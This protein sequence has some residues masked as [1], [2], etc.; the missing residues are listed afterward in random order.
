MG[1]KVGK[2]YNLIF[3]E[4]VENLLKSIPKGKITETIENAIKVYI[5]GDRGKLE[6]ELKDL[7]DKRVMLNAEIERIT[8]KLRI[9][10]AEEDAKILILLKEIGMSKTRPPHI[11]PREYNDV[12][13][14]LLRHG[15]K[16]TK[17]EVLDVLEGIE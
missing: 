15:I 6:A 11:P 10:K 9:I 1:K 3:E 2:Q 7:E 16:R 8:E 17:K 12:Y 5:I 14:F 4:E 13:P